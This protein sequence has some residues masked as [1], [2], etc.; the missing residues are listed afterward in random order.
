MIKEG[1][2]Q[3]RK[4]QELVVAVL[5][6]ATL[7]I[8]SVS[9]FANSDV[10]FYE[11]F[12]GYS[13]EEDVEYAWLPFQNKGPLVIVQDPSYTGGK[14]A[15][16]RLEERSRMGCGLYPL[17][18]IEKAI[19]EIR[20]YDPNNPYENGSAGVAG[21][22]DP[23]ASFWFFVGVGSSNF[24]QPKH[25]NNYAYRFYGSTPGWTLTEVERSEGWHVLRFAFDKGVFTAFIDDV[26]V[27]ETDAAPFTE[28]G[29]IALGS[30]WPVYDDQ[31]V[32]D[33]VK[34]TK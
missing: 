16:V 13:S 5:V 22:T 12:S 32:F 4:Y 23:M 24:G 25:A 3:V 14:G 26:I 11:D 15:T 7:L 27:F 28:L 19:V 1:V 30:L 17:D 33:T 21:I 29:G 9:A 10:V 8:S 31:I 2:L 6:C 20:F 18:P 34:V